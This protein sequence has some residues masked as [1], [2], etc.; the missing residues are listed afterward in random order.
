MRVPRSVD[1]RQILS[2]AFL[3]TGVLLLA[4]LTVG[5]LNRSRVF[6]GDVVVNRYASGNPDWIQLY[7]RSRVELDLSGFLLS[8]GQNV[9][10]LPAGLRIAPRDSVILAAAADSAALRR[11]GVDVRWH[12]PRWRLG[13][14]KRE[15]ILLLD[16]DGNTMIDFVHTL[17][18]NAGES[19]GRKTPGGHE[20]ALY[21]G[22][23]SGISGCSYARHVDSVSAA[24]ETSWN[25]AERERPGAIMQSTITAVGML[26][27]LAQELALLL[28]ALA[29]LHLAV[30]AHIRA[31]FRD[32]RR[33]P[34]RVW[35][36]KV[37]RD[38]PE[39]VANE[40]A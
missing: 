35:V 15:F 5:V 3:L 6:P 1:A 27:K 24:R 34:D 9:S 31:T 39:P 30:F 40:P 22:C 29:A 25:R 33:N 20:W 18:L 19:L 23:S 17:T 28:T 12:W 4:W 8:D 26:T 10:R 21:L 13:H 7:N 14:D 37:H 2:W 11:T 38:S 36:D 16:R 32:R